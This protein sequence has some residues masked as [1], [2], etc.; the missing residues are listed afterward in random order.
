MLRPYTYLCSQAPQPVHQS[1]TGLTGDLSKGDI[2][3]YPLTVKVRTRAYK[4]VHGSCHAVKPFH[5]LN[6]VV[7]TI[8][9]YPVKA[10]LLERFQPLLIDIARVGKDEGTGLFQYGYGVLYGYADQ[11]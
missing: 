10:D 2:R 7:G 1:R 3:L 6:T 8:N 11:S 4:K 9:L 5:C